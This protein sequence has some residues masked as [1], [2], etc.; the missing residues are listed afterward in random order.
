[1]SYKDIEATKQIS[2]TDGDALKTEKNQRQISY[3]ERKATKANKLQRVGGY[4]G[5]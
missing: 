4:K 3:N 2:Y 1:M 5:G